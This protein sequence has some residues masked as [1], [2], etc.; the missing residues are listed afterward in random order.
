MAGVTTSEAPAARRTQAERSAATQARLLDATVDCL[1]ERGWAGTSTT[2]VVRR[3]GVSRG[4]QVHHFPTKEDLVLAAVEHLLERRIAEFEATFADLPPE[5]R[6]PATAMRL[7]YE[8]CFCDTFEAWLELVVAA[9]TDAALHARFVLV[10]SR[11]VDHALA[12][13]QGLFADAAADDTFAR[14][15]LRLAFSLLD[16]LAIG[17]LTDVDGTE[18]DAVLDVFNQLVAPYFPNTPG[19]TSR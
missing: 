8:N 10:E 16:G 1:V 18:L 9:R 7:L 4:A 15:A 12:T 6:S 13:F 2:E 11:F 5:Q 19:G 3:A 14:V 17:R